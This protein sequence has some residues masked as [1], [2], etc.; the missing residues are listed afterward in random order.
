MTEVL[1]KPKV[2]LS[3]SHA[4]RG[5]AERFAGTLRASGTEVWKADWDRDNGRSL[6]QSLERGLRASD[7]VVILFDAETLQ[8]PNALFELG[9][10]MAGNKA[11]VP[12]VPPGVSVARLPVPLQ[13]V[14]FLA[15]GSPEATAAQLIEEVLRQPPAE[16]DGNSQEV[17]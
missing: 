9:A 8:N 16:S 2:F 3:Y 15:K 13:R 6:S 4:D 10:A 17:H 1:V 5:W 14:V 11:V 7:V 12:V